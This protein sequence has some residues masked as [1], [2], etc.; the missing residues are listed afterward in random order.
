MTHEGDNERTIGQLLALNVFVFILYWGVSHVNWLIFKSVGVLPMPI[1]PG[2]AV[3]LVAATLYGWPLAPAIALGTIMSNHYSLSA[4]WVY[5][6]CIS[7]MNTL[8]P[9]LCAFIIRRCIAGKSW[10]TLSRWDVTVL[11]LSGVVLLPLL[12]ACGGIGSKWLLGLLPLAEVPQAF[13]RWTLS[14]GLGALIFAPPFL[15]WLFRGDT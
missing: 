11:F 4:P 12:S 5:A 14:H 1:W 8:A 2:A 13:M 10:L 15:I 7:V 3:A 6:I 9:L